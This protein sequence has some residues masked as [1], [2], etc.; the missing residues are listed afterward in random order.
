[1]FWL[2]YIKAFWLFYCSDC[3]VQCSCYVPDLHDDNRSQLS[4]KHRLTTNFFQYNKSFHKPDSQA[5]NTQKKDISGKM[6]RS[7]CG[8]LVNISYD[9]SSPYIA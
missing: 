9:K 1:V 2:F 5:H 4:Q 6:W 7:W 8:K 3:P